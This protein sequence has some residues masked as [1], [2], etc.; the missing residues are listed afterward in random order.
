MSTAERRSPTGHRQSIRQY[1]V[2]L[3]QFDRVAHQSKQRGWNAL[4]AAS[5][6]PN[7]FRYLRNGSVLENA[8]YVSITVLNDAGS[9]PLKRLRLSEQD[10]IGVTDLADRC[11]MGI[12]VLV[13]IDLVV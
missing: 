6:A 11:L 8:G 9:I 13:G 10:L 3:G 5:S 1:H 2:L 4:R 12:K 7:G